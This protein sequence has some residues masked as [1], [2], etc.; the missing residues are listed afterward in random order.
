LDLLSFNDNI[1]SRLAPHYSVQ[2]HAK[3]GAVIDNI[4]VTKITDDMIRHDQGNACQVV[5]IGLGDNNLRP[6][7]LLRGHSKDEVIQCFSSLCITAARLKK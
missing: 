4:I 3:G 2:I 1:Y 6:R 7:G 5:V